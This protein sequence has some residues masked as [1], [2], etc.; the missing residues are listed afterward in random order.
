MP[1]LISP[2]TPTFS[3]SASSKLQW[4]VISSI[5]IIGFVIMISNKNPDCLSENNGGKTS[6]HAVTTHN[7]ENENGEALLLSSS[8]SSSF[9]RTDNSRILSEQLSKLQGLEEGLARARSGIRN[10]ARNQTSHGE[11]KNSIYRNAGEFHWSYSKMEKMFKIYVYEGLYST[12]G[13]FINGIETS[14]QLR[15]RDPDRAHVYF[16]P[17]SIKVMVR[18]LYESDS[19]D[20]EPIKRTITEYVDVIARKYPYWNR[21]SGA[22]HSMLSC[23][24][25]G[26]RT[27]SSIPMLYKNSIRA[28]CNANTSEGFNPSKDLSFPEINLRKGNLPV[29]VEGLPPSDRSILGFFAG[30]LHGNIRVILVQHWKYKDDKILVYE[31][32]PAG[33]S[34]GT[35]MRKSRF[36]LR[37]SGYEVASPRIVES[38][39]SECVPVLIS[40]H[41][42]P[43]FSDVLNWNSFSV[44]VRVNEIP[45]LKTILMS[46]T[47]ERYLEL[48][49]NLK[50][51]LKHFMVNDPPV[52]YDAFYMTIHSIWLR[53]LNI[54]INT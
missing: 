5:L 18:Y 21:S 16:L 43:P 51:V 12:E 17:F 49:K 13:M 26:P 6:P 23:H 44:Q 38:F 4:V 24:D 14:K 39:Y 2:S 27:S 32:L 1:S 25:W 42:V 46:I 45:N 20:I 35:M 22:D 3:S 37:P 8:S 47:E 54:R 10:A 33:I 48:H 40:D 28:L 53:R 41:Y 7:Q 34:Y 29:I 9:R 50:Q 30:R 31:H 11:D 36:C 52:R 15:T 19:Q